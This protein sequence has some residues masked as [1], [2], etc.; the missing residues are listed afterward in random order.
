MSQQITYD[1]I[2]IL[3]HI[4]QLIQSNLINPYQAKSKNILSMVKAIQAIIIST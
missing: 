3:D 1:P 4:I 2:T